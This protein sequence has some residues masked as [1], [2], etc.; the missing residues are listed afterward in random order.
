MMKKETVYFSMWDYYI[1][2]VY[3]C[4]F[5]Y[6]LQMYVHMHTSIQLLKDMQLTNIAPKT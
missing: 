1:L 6:A 5:I 2:H 4:I 3:N